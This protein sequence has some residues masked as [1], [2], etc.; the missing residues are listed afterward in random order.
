MLPAMQLGAPPAFL[1]CDGGWK[2]LAVSQGGSLQ[3]WDLH[4]QQLI[5][6]ASIAPLLG[7]AAP[8]I[9]GASPML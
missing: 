2:L 1:A 4:A 9:T 7:T 3:L 8:S 6:Q 5:V